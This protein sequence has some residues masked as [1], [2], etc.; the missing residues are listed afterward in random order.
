MGAI[1]PP[2]GEST[3]VH[4][5]FVHLSFPPFAYF[6]QSTVTWS[7]PLRFLL[8]Q[9][10]VQLCTSDVCPALLSIESEGLEME[11]A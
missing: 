5:H 4:V 9:W 8:A 2:S 3:H 7:F 10:S 6:P 11:G 1:W